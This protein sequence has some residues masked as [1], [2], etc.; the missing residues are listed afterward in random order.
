MFTEQ[1]WEQIARSL[2]LSG[3][4][5]QIVRGV[6]D[7]RIEP[8]IASDLGVAPCTVHTHL[9]RLHRKLAVHDRAQLVVRVMREFLVLAGAPDSPLP[10]ICGNRAAGRCPLRSD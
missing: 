4:E 3:R 9:E 8:A 5:L 6:F 1:A 7:D 2:G 10:S